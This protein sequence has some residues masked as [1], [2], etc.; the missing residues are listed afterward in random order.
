MSFKKEHLS[1]STINSNKE[2]SLAERI[3]HAWHIYTSDPSQY[4]LEHKN[5]ALVF[6]QTCF[7]T[8][9]VEQ[10]RLLIKLKKQNQSNFVVT[11][12]LD[13]AKEYC[14]EYIHNLVVHN[15]GY[16]NTSMNK[17]MQEQLQFISTAKD[18]VELDAIRDRMQSILDRII[19]ENIVYEAKKISKI[20]LQ[21]IE[22]YKFGKD[23][24]EMKRFIE[25]YRNAVDQV[26]NAEASTAIT[27]KLYLVLEQMQSNPIIQKARDSLVL[28]R[29]QQALLAIDM[30]TQADKIEVAMAQIPLTERGYIHLGNTVE[31]KKVLQTLAT[32][33]NVFNKIDGE[34]PQY[35]VDGNKLEH[36]SSEFKAKFREMK[37]SQDGFDNELDGSSL[38]P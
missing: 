4:N 18:V 26:E 7:A 13:R 29:S 10:I 2:N 6:L 9:S 35:V 15:F 3:E 16:H 30:K 34:M 22:K 25:R 33:S 38:E 28:C 37:A 24:V 17:L 21:H 14:R 20:L 8:E 36:S 1:D 23:D 11:V 5:K 19:S 12:E 27:K 31:S 32:Q